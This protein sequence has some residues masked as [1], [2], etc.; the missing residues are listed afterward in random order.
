[1]YPKYAQ[2]YLA[3][4]IG[5]LFARELSN[6]IF[7]SEEKHPKYIIRDDTI[8]ILNFASSDDNGYYMTGN[9]IELLPTQGRTDNLFDNKKRKILI[10]GDGLYDNKN[11]KI[12]EQAIKAALIEANQASETS[13]VIIKNDKSLLVV[14][15]GME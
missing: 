2:I 5:N 11:K 14:A 7:R 9:F 10:N 1:M 12:I 3:R 6:I 8:T 4:S 15:Y 13:V